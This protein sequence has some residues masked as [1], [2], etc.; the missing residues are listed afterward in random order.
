MENWSFGD[1]ASYKDI[2]SRLHLARRFLN[3]NWT[4]LA[5]S[6]G[7][8]W[9][10]GMRFSSSVYLAIR[11]C[12][13]CVL[14]SNHCSSL[15]TSLTGSINVR[16]RFRR[17]SARADMFM[18]VPLPDGDTCSTNKLMGDYYT[19]HT[20]FRNINILKVCQEKTHLMR[21]QCSRTSKLYSVYLFLRFCAP[22]TAY[23]TYCDNY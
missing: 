18:P 17:S 14:C 11:L 15:G 16:F 2:F 7:N 13:G 1:M 3:Q 4:F 12:D 9:R 21:S 20:V 10:Y 8:F 23:R 5:S 6:R 19:D 22:R